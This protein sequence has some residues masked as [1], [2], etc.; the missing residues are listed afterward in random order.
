LPGPEGGQD[1]QV[2]LSS[3][4]A[5]SAMVAPVVLITTG[6]LLSN[7]L[8]I[9]YGAT[10]DRMR[11]MTGERISIRSGP[12]GTLLDEAACTAVGK[13]RLAEID[14]QLPM[15]LRRHRLTRNAVLLM[16]AGIGV[17][18]LSVI[19]IA[20]A[21][22]R[23]SEGFGRSA[24]GLVLA[25]TVVMLAGLVVAARSMASSADAISYA[26]KRTG[27]GELAAAPQARRLGRGDRMRT[28]E[29]TERGNAGV[30][31]SRSIAKE[32]TCPITSVRP[33]SSR[34]TTIRGW[35]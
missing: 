27:S 13:E 4:S 17:L 11:Q 3:V 30:G 21:V 20:L 23:N 2:T 29:P 14:R 12:G 5:I 19:D 8:L 35:T 25:G 33:T 24:L 32:R 16:Y 34:P 9:V 6:A 22:T 26:V 1:Q 15:I 10:N 31:D 28:S 7:G 18:V